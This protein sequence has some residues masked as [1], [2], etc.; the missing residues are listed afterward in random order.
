MKNAMQLGFQKSDLCVFTKTY[1]PHTSIALPDIEEGGSV[2][3]MY[4]E[5]RIIVQKIIKVSSDAYQ[6]TISGFEP[7]V[8]ITYKCLMLGE[9]IEFQDE[10]IFSHQEK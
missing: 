10:H 2:T 9:Q 1:Q 8:S 3:L 7:S 6:G 5:E 4:D